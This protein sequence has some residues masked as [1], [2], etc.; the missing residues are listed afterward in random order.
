MFTGPFIAAGGFTRESGAAAVASG[1][2][3]LVAY[4]RHWLANPDLPKRFLLGAPLNKYNRVR[5]G[6]EG[7]VCGVWY[8]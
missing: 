3:D 2:T 8:I 4:G 5:G 6:S 7:G 1:H